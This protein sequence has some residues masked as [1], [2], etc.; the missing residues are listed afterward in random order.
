MNP[1]EQDPRRPAAGEALRVPTARELPSL[2]AHIRARLEHHRDE[3]DE[4][5]VFP[6]PDG[7]TG[8]NLL[9][10]ATAALRAA[11]AVA[12][13]GADDV[14]EA[15]VIREAVQGALRGACG[16]SGVILSQVL[17]AL[18][19]E[20]ADHPLHPGPLAASLA[21][22]RDLSY[23]A[24]ADPV[25]GT[26]LT[27]LTAAAGAAADAAAVGEDLD[28]ALAA[29]TTAVSVAV[30]RTREQL[31]VLAEAGVV[32]AGARGLEVVLSALD[33][34]S[35]G[36]EIELPPA[37]RPV[38][39]R[40][41][42]PVRPRETGSEEF[43]HEVQYLLQ[44][45]DPDEGQRTARALRARLR[46]LGDSVV[47]V[48]AGATVRV[49][50]H[51]NEIAAAIAAGEERGSPSAVEVATFAD[52]EGGGADH[53]GMTGAVAVVPG[54]GLARV[55]EDAG[56]VA[57]PGRPGERPNVARL[58]EAVGAVHAPHVLILPGDPD[59]V[60][61]ARQT[62]A[63]SEAEGGRPIEVVEA[64][65][66]VP[67]VL[68]ALA[69]FDPASA[70]QDAREVMTVAAGDVQ[71]GAIV[72]AARDATTPIGDVAEDQLLVLVG[73]EVVAAV[74]SVDEALAVLV[75]RCGRGCEVVTIVVGAGVDAE[76]AA[77]SQKLLVTCLPEAEVM[78]LEGEQE[79]AR[80]LLGFE[81][82]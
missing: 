22:A 32:D 47:V 2:L 3:L 4:L 49:H 34:W 12:E 66:S 10:T 42:R 37:S 71:A 15:A 63:V 70:P 43:A 78:L 72:P 1:Q 9:A 21:R 35:R 29:V 75:E 38:E 5:N 28:G 26:I 27:A 25:E 57:V 51:T 11:Q 58:L 67:A 52:A 24:V 81:G 18:A 45:E 14:D 73:G 13:T 7:D 33:G 36:H 50:V 82:P 40:G 76:E 8:T 17:R 64:A 6:V 41:E 23:E 74:D 44:L 46:E 20:L 62:A 16:N 53:S 65:D 61:A 31:E 59:V 60:A 55:V 77:A 39:R 69:V 19:E 80:Y 68:A 48:A 54:P 30:A 79:P 56:A